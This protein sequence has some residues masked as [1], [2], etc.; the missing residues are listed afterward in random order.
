MSSSRELTAE[1]F[2]QQVSQSAFDLA[3]LAETFREIE[4]PYRANQDWN[5]RSDV[6]VNLF[7]SLK[8]N[9]D[10]K[11]IE[12]IFIKNPVPSNKAYRINISI[13]SSSKTV[14]L[15]SCEF[16][17]T[18]KVLTQLKNL[19]NLKQQDD[20]TQRYYQRQF[21]FYSNKTNKLKSNKNS[22]K[23][24]DKIFNLINPLEN[25]TCGSANAVRDGLINIYSRNEKLTQNL[26]NEIVLAIFVGRDILNA[27]KTELH[28]VV[29]KVI[30]SV[31]DN[32]LEYAK[33][34]KIPVSK[35]T[36][37]IELKDDSPILPTRV[38]HKPKYLNLRPSSVFSH[39]VSGLFARHKK[40]DLD[41]ATVPL[42][43]KPSVI[44]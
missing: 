25:L 38:I 22:A 16:V 15:S 30:A 37:D 42:L 3:I 18:E 10:V 36:P 43:Q 4:F 5:F 21:E 28:P 34:M 19:G 32:Y 2:V 11:E 14:E 26:A 17:S 12:A 31:A 41:D 24:V 27:R 35:K 6:L 13:E 8:A 44:I 23:F 40:I 20:I 29:A 9:R 33:S 1:Q 39:K 7:L